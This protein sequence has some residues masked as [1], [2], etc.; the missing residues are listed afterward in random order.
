[1]TDSEKRKLIRNVKAE[2]RGALLRRWYEDADLIY[3]VLDTLDP[4]DPLAAE[5]YS[6]GKDAAWIRE[7]PK[8]S[9]EGIQWEQRRAAVVRA[10]ARR[11]C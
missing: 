2:V 6:L 8:D 4:R 10:A 3:N 5:I 11:I 7:L 1:M 9:D